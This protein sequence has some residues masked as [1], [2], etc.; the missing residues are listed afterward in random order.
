MTG[1]LNHGQILEA[2][3]QVINVGLRHQTSVI[4]VMLDL[5]HFKKVND[6]FG[7]AA[8]DKVIIGLSQLLLQNIRKTDYIGR[9][10]GEEFLLVF[11]GGTIKTVKDKLNHIRETFA[12]INFIQGN[13]E[14]Q[15]TLSAGFAKLSTEPHLAP[16]LEA[17]D[18]KLY[19]TKSNG[20]NCIVS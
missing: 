13:S 14:F 11:Q 6:T 20:R 8:G 5:E 9:Y 3:Q 17:A 2:A 7:H 19:D 1:L 18:N 4:V 10:G 15:V 16:L 12:Q